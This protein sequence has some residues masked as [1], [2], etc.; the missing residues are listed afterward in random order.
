MSER[1]RLERIIAF[2]L[3]IC[4]I[5]TSG[6]VVYLSIVGLPVPSSL[7]VIAG[8]VIGALGGALSSSGL[9]TRKPNG[10]ST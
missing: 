2:A 1:A 3:S 4:G 10:T 9:H 6:G 7:A 5:I 8:A